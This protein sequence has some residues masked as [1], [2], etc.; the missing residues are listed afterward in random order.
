[1]S[2]VSSITEAGSLWERY[3][4]PLMWLGSVWVPWAAMVKAVLLLG[5]VALANPFL[6]VS[7]AVRGI[8]FTTETFIPFVYCIHIIMCGV[9]VLL[10]ASYHL[11]R[12]RL[13]AI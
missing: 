11:L 5:Y 10:F 4:E 1:S 3:V 7:E 12:R 9:V 13:D 6:Y 8:F 2:M